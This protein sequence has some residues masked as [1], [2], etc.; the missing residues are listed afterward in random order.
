MATEPLQGLASNHFPTKLFSFC[1][2]HSIY[3]EC[4]SLQLPSLPTALASAN[5]SA[6]S[7]CLPCDWQMSIVSI[8]FHFDPI[9]RLCLTYAFFVHLWIETTFAPMTTETF[10]SRYHSCR[11][12]C[13]RHLFGMH[14]GISQISK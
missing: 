12:R 11:V 10:G 14:P 8:F 13:Y 2:S 3:G 1:L 4:S 5:W 7:D 6:G 9:L